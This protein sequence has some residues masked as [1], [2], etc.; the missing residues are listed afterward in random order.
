MEKETAKNRGTDE[1]FLQL[2]SVCGSAVL[3]LLGIAPEEAEKYRFAA[4]VL[5]EKRIEPDVVGIPVFEGEWLRVYIEFQGYYDRFIRYKLAA[6][7]F[8][9]CTREK[10]DGKVLAAVIFTDKS[11]QEI[12]LPPNPFIESDTCCF[13]GCFTEIV[14]T[15]FTEDQ[16][17]KI[18]QKLVVLA[19]FTLPPK[20]EKAELLTKGKRW[21][22]CLTEAFPPHQKQDAVNVLCL[23]LLNRFR[24]ISRE[25]VVHMMNIDISDTV[26]GRQIFEEG[27]LKTARDMVLGALEE[28]FKI[29]PG[30]IIARVKSI[31]KSEI[32]M[33]LLRQAIRSKELEDFK[34]ILAKG[35]A[36]E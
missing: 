4:E 14:L 29:V 36:E 23:L 27:A 33:N 2:M 9:G 3:K 21:K 7:V 15:D 32:L 22:E 11:H 20:M 19:P 1:A 35:R 24:N 12:A 16:L 17:K 8:L 10:Y 13:T 31:D 6:K 34:Q 26:A 30:D 18:D 25:E 5:K 28:R